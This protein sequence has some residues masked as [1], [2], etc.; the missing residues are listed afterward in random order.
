MFSG[1]QAVKPLV[2]PENRLEALHGA[3]RLGLSAAGE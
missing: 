1:Y 2:C 3:C